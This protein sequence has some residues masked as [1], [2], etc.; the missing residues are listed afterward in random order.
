[1]KATGESANPWIDESARTPT[2]EGGGGIEPR[3]RTRIPT[4]EGVAE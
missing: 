3:E 2:P 4:L 1:M